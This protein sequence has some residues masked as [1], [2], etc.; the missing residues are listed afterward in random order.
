MSESGEL[1][2]TVNYIKHK[3][4]ALEKIEMLNLSSNEVLREKY[5]RLLK[6]DD[7]LFQV[8]KLIDGLKAQNEIA[9]VIGTNDM[10]VSRKI[11][12]LEENGLIEIKDIGANGKRIYKHSVAEQAFK[13][14]R[15]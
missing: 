15:I 1:Y 5:V 10:A 8:Y 13:L 11:K 3:V 14:T 4:D 7:V 2:A 12:K 9:S 6:S